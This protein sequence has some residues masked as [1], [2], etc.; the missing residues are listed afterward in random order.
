MRR[1]SAGFG[2][3]DL[4]AINGPRNRRDASEYAFR[5]SMARGM[6]WVPDRLLIF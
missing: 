3:V 4:A 2:A 6:G 1:P 5:E